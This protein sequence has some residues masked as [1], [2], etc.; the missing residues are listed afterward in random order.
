M[1]SDTEQY[2]RPGRAEVDR[3][4]VGERHQRLD[5]REV[6]EQSMAAV[7]A[8][9]DACTEAYFASDEW[10][11]DLDANDLDPDLFAGDGW[12]DEMEPEVIERWQSTW[13]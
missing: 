7:Q 9:L 11:L 6:A 4:Q 3:E 10:T 12:I 5:E 13:P 1:T 2:L 8:E